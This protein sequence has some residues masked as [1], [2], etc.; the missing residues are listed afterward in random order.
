MNEFQTETAFF[1]D[2]ATRAKE[3]VESFDGKA[4][5]AE[6]KEF[7]GDFSTEV[8]IAVENLVVAE[9]NKHFPSDV[10]MAEEGRAET[11]IPDGRIWLIDPICGTGNLGR[12]LKSFCT[13]IALADKRQLVASCVIDHSRGEYYWSVGGGQVYI[14]D[15]LYVR[16]QNDEKFGVLIDVDFGALPNVD[17]SQKERLAKAA[18][19]LSQQPGYMLQSLSSSL[20]FAYT[21]V[22]KIDGFIN[23]YNHPWDICAASFLIQQSGGAITNLDGKPWNIAAVGAIGAV[24]EE[25]HK[26]LLD[27]YL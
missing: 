24:S 2:I 21:G 7:V 27:A 3:L 10:I 8:D 26:K 25:I 22:G 23:V 4:D 15:K 9:I 17:D 16:S 5:V 12:G 20:G 1:K 13:N 11:K 18:L 6:Y 19:E 14:N